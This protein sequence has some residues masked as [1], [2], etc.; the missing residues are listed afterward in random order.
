MDGTAR[1]P[2]KLGDRVK[3]YWLA[4]RMAKRTGVDLN[5]AATSGD[6]SQDDWSNVVTRCQGCAWTEGCQK[7]LGQTDAVLQ[8]IP[9]TCEN[10]QTLK[11][12]KFKQRT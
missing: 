3:H 7:F 2:R 12:L 9:A 11:H 1:N 4:Q 5:A 10:S 6:L 8:P